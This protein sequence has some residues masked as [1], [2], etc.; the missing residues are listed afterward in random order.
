MKV[1]SLEIMRV[2]QKYDKA[3]KMVPNKFVA[4]IKCVATDNITGERKSRE[5]A[6]EDF[7]FRDGG[8]QSPFFR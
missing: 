7:T 3:G 6:T 8:W 1:Q 2:V 4:A 5:F